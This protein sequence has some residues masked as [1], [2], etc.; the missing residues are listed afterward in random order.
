MA[1]GFLTDRSSR[2]ILAMGFR[3]ALDVMRRLRPNPSPVL[4][5]PSVIV[6][7]HTTRSVVLHSCRSELR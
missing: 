3:V 1:F 6:V 4:R 5:L 7:V 2:L